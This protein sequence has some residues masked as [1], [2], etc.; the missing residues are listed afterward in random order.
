MKKWYVVPLLALLACSASAKPTNNAL[1]LVLNEYQ[2]KP[3]DYTSVVQD[4]QGGYE[5]RIYQKRGG[6]PSYDAW[7]VSFDEEITYLGYYQAQY[8]YVDI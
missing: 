1:E 2:I 5:V 7:F 3:V 6:Y 4:A 8:R